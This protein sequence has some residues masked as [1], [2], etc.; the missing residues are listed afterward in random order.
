MTNV[1]A[2]SFVSGYGIIFVLVILIAVVGLLIAG[3]RF[4][5]PLN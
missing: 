2:G 5:L 3:D 1:P 4:K